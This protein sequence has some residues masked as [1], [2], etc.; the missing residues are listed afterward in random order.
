[1]AERHSILSRIGRNIRTRILTGILVVVP[2]G[3][4]I[5]I[6]WFFVNLG[7]RILQPVLEEVIGYRIPGLG[8]IVTVIL[9]Y[10]IGLFASLVFGRRMIHW[11]ES[12]LKRIPLVKNIYTAAKQVVEVISQPKSQAFK[13]VV[14]TEF[15]RSGMWV[16]AFVTGEL[17]NSDGRKSIKLFI[18]TTPNPTS[19]YLVLVP[20][21]QV[22]EANMSVEEGIKMIVSGG[23]L[24]PER[25]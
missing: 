18:P 3:I 12:I 1:M 25:L 17:Y 19:G 20:E 5:W 21:D 10:W 24:S 23:I 16:V 9:L 8:L 7:D 2:L 11:G 15:P 22:R 14:L 4:T 13:R 6:L